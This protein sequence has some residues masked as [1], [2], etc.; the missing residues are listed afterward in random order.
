MKHLQ[1]FMFNT[2]LYNSYGFVCQIIIFPMKL[3]ITLYVPSLLC[4][5]YGFRVLLSC[6]DFGDIKMA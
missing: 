5:I 3:W 2:L 1:Y 6:F 4:M